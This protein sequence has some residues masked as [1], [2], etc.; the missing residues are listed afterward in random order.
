[1]GKGKRVRQMRAVALQ[2]AGAGQVAAQRKARKAELG[3][4]G[5]TQNWFYIIRYVAII[6][7][8]VHHFGKVLY[9]I[10]RIDEIA[11]LAC[12]VIGRVAFPLFVFELIESFYITKNKKKHLLWLGI[13][14]L[15]SELPFDV[16]GVLPEPLQF[17]WYAMRVQNVC[18]TLFW[19]FLMLM[20]IDVLKP[21]AFVKMYKREGIRRCVSMAARL[22]VVALFAFGAYWAMTDY[23]WYGIVFIALFAFARTRPHI[24]FWQGAAIFWFAISFGNTLL[25]FVPLVAS[26][27]LIYAAEI[28]S[29]A[30]AASGVEE[31]SN[32]VLAGNASK[33]F[34]RVFYPLHLIILAVVRIIFTKV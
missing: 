13:L 12:Y 25:V 27:L 26:V 29:K 23:S 16:M 7:M 14:A 33:L 5:I 28:R 20:V 30:K 32:P 1:M 15:V 6:S 10:G 18:F 2:S 8:L 21:D 17:S 24:K 11:Y 19:G 3:F 34:C 4:R 9:I 31:A 22:V